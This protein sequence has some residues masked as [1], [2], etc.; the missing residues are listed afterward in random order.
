MGA[1]LEL[2]AS[3]VPPKPSILASPTAQ[4]KLLL[5]RTGPSKTTRWRRLRAISKGAAFP[6]YVHASII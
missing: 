3:A 4:V 6:P 1:K 2:N 5:P